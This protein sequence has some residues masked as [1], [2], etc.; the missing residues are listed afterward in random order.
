MAS[1]RIANNKIHGLFD[2]NGA[3]CVD[4]Q[5]IESVVIGCFSDLFKAWTTPPD[6]P[7]TAEEIRNAIFDMVP[8]KAPSPNGLPA[9]FYYKFWDTIG[10]NVTEAGHR[11]LNEGENL[12]K[13]TQCDQRGCFR[14]SKCFYARLDDSNNIIIG[15]ESPHALRTRKRKAGSVALKVDMSKVYAAVKWGFLQ[16]VML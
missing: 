7:F 1:V 2:S 9:L 12:S 10:I 13:A 4:Q 16:N 5:E 8:T 3:Y 15:L 11:S 14:D 6:L